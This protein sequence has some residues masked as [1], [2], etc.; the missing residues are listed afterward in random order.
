MLRKRWFSFHGVRR[1]EGVIV[2]KRFARRQRVV[3]GAKAVFNDK[4]SV[5]D[6]RIRDLST[7]G[8]RL[9]LPSTV[10]LPNEFDLVESGS[11]I[12]RYCEVV[13][14]TFDAVGVKFM[15]SAA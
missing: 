1:V 8:A 9:V 2:N 5:M 7:T 4:C 10:G 12:S 15:P 14:R 6:C 3:K 11:G 13:W